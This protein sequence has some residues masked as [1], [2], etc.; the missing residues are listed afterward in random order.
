MAGFY[1]QGLYNYY[2]NMKKGRSRRRYFKKPHHS[3]RRSYRGVDKKFMTNFLKITESKFIDT[4]ISQ[5]PVTGTSDIVVLNAIGVGDTDILRDGEN[6]LI[7]S[8]QYNL[9]IQ[10]D[11]NLI[12]DTD[13]DI[14][15][16]LKRDVRGAQLI[17]TDVFV[18][19]T[20]TALRQVQNSK[21]FKILHRRRTHQPAPRIVNQVGRWQIR[22]FHK[23]KK[24][25]RV[26]Y[27]S[28]AATV[29]ALDRNS[30]SI[31]F[32]TNAGATFEPGIT[33][34]IRVTFKDV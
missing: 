25:I 32:M 1:A 14:M 5:T 28:T 22:Y 30:I 24:P 9:Q 12:E 6:L 3:K 17:P 26:K 15:L 7:T 16:I 33:G 20:I 23:F 21:N 8:I 29:A 10:A 34:N 27:L 19:D 11:A 18:S 31:M 13:L 2:R 4:A